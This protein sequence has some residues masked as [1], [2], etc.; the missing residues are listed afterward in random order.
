MK[1]DEALG[2]FTSLASLIQNCK[3]ID[4]EVKFTLYLFTIESNVLKV[5]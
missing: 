5:T 2:L 1:Q 3:P 4:R